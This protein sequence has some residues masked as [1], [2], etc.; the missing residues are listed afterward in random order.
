MNQF[1]NERYAVNDYVYGTEPN[2]YFKAQ[3][4]K[5]NPGKIL[6]PGEGEGRNAVF[7]AKLGWDV[8]AFDGSSEGKRKAE[9]L[10]AKNN[11]IINYKV[12]DYDS[13]D[14]AP[15][16]FDA[17]ALIFTHMHPEKR[18]GYHRKLITFLK[19]GGFLILEGFA[20]NQINRNTGGPRNIDMLFS[21]DELKNDFSS[22]N[23]L[24]ITEN[25]IHF[26]EGIFHDGNAS[27]VRI[28]GMK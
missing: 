5:L 19:P 12:L 28:F 20:K 2:E 10:A 27:V 7:S 6:L 18:E 3:L 22:L 16:T 15:E 1:W 11:V 26:K 23:K 13:V 25:E 4:E 8:I 24:N 21:K 17:I 14:F 9:K